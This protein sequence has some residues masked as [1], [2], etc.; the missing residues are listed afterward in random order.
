MYLSPMM[1]MMYNIILNDDLA[2]DLLDGQV[3]LPDLRENGLQ[4][5]LSSLQLCN[6]NC[7]GG[8]SSLKII[9]M[10]TKKTLPKKF[11]PLDPF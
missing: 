4:G 9:A 5:G 8:L 2:T 7:Q 10:L 3:R 1:T 11:K 6:C